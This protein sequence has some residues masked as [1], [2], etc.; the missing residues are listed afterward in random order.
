MQER[1]DPLWLNASR[2]SSSK[3]LQQAGRSLSEIDFFEAH[4]AFTIMSALSLEAVGFAERGRGI[5][6][7]RTEG[8]GLRGALPMSTMGGLKARGHPVGATGA[9]QIVESVLQLRG[10]A[11]LN[12][13]SSPRVALVQ[14]F[15][16]SC[17]T[18]IT[19]VLERSKN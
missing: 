3:A 10:E 19:H 15:G 1:E 18:A 2:E 9:Y 17:A 7:A 12:Q 8:I 5:E 11:G 14:S 16:G 6:F 4:D 13:L